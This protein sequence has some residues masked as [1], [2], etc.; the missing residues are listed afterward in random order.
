MVICTSSNPKLPTDFCIPLL[1]FVVD[2]TEAIT[3]WHMC[4][5]N[6]WRESTFKCFQ[7]VFRQAVHLQCF[8]HLKGILEAKLGEFGVPKHA[9]IEMFLVILFTFKMAWSIPRV[10]I[11]RRF[12]IGCKW[13]GMNEREHTMIR[14]NLFNGLYTTAKKKY[15]QPCSRRT[16]GRLG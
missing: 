8:L 14:L 15:T 7:T 12:S 1:H 9:K 10:T 5:C 3:C 6:R 2:W 16:E 11:L 13:C 4:L